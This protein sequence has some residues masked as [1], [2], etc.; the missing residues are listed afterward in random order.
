MVHPKAIFTQSDNA[1]ICLGGCKSK[2]FIGKHGSFKGG[3]TL[4]ILWKGDYIRYIADIALCSDHPSHV[5]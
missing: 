2:A 4:N 3:L 5:F 1:S